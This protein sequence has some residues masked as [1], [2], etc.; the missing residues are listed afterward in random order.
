MP[1]FE[2]IADFPHFTSRKFHIPASLE[3]S[4]DQYNA[5]YDRLK[6]L[7]S[8]ARAPVLYE[9]AKAID[10]APMQALLIYEWWNLADDMGAYALRLAR[11]MERARDEVSIQS[12]LNWRDRK[13]YDGLVEQVTIWQGGTFATEARPSWTT[14]R[15][16]AEQFAKGHRQFANQTPEIWQAKVT[17]RFILMVHADR[18]EAEVVILPRRARLVAGS[19]RRFDVDK[20]SFVPASPT[21]T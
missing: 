7:G 17:K 6:M 16:V 4:F 13:F 21:R 8:H 15:A 12:L 1:K 14:D 18:D 10:H 20:D 11:L 5:A 2:N 3:R 19:L 9:E